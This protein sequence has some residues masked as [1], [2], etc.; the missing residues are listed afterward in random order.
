[1]GSSVTC[2]AGTSAFL[3]LLVVFGSVNARAGSGR[4]PPKRNPRGGGGFVLTPPQGNLVNAP[5]AVVMTTHVSTGR[6]RSWWLSAL[7]EL[8]S[9]ACSS[10][11]LHNQLS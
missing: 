9:I 7:V 10:N 6:M 8:R 1:M 4:Q 3:G 11:G 2:M 5:C